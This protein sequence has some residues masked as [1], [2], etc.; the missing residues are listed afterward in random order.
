MDSIFT[1]IIKKEI[2]AYIIDENDY[3]ISIL[4]INPI[5][6]GHTLIIPKVQIDYFFDIDNDLLSKTMPY[7]KKISTA[8][9][10][11][12]ECERIGLSIIGLEVPHAHIHLIPINSINDMNFNNAKPISKDEMI[13]IQNKIKSFL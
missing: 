4:D 3:F 6:L 8:I 1:K 7:C 5:K 9:K 11:A 13:K 12:I 10:K 2:P